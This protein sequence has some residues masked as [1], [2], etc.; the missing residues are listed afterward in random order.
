MIIKLTPPQ[1]VEY[2]EMIK[3]SYVKGDLVQDDQRQVV[4][5]K[6][7]QELLSE[8]AQ[9][10]LRIS[11]DRQMI[12]LM[13]TKIM[14][15]NISGDKFLYIQCIFSFRKVPDNQ[16]EEDWKFLRTFA[17]SNKCSYI[18]AESSNPQIFKIM[19]QLSAMELY[20]TYRYE[21]TNE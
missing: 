17:K 16:W 3:F 5:N 13:I 10:F 19:Q 7:L 21:L 15:S 4:L 18:E 20:R 12:A 14:I 6:L 2:W 11:D 1:I 8:K 9:C